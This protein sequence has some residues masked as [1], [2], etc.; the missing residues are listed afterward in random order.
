MIEGGWDSFVCRIFLL[1]RMKLFALD[2]Y[3]RNF[4][5]WFVNVCVLFFNSF[6][7][8]IRRR[9]GSPYLQILHKFYIDQRVLSVVC[10]NS[11]ETTHYL[12]ILK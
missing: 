1:C 2:K 9:P 4:E 11:Q 10:H 5:R 6:S 3:Y 8:A 12:H 7:H